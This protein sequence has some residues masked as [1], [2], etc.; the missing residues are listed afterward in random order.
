MVE[1]KDTGW[2]AVLEKKGLY[3]AAGIL[4]NYG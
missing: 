1:G 3:Q 2:L 4:E